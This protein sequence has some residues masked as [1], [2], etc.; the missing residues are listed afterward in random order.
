MANRQVSK[1]VLKMIDSKRGPYKKYTHEKKA[2]VARYDVQHGTSG[3]LFPHKTF[4]FSIVPSYI[5]NVGGVKLHVTSKIMEI[6]L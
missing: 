4:L 6:L 1:L 2:T 3:A 5:E